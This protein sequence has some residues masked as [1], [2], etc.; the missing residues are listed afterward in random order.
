MLTLQL[1]REKR[2]HKQQTVTYVIM[3]H[4]LISPIVTTT[5]THYR[6]S[7][8]TNLLTHSSPTNLLSMSPPSLRSRLPAHIPL[9]LLRIRSDGQ[10]DSSHPNNPHHVEHEAPRRDSTRVFGQRLRPLVTKKETEEEKCQPEVP[11]RRNTRERGGH[12]SAMRTT[13][14]YDTHIDTIRVKTVRAYPIQ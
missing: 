7:P 8:S 1:N 6:P 13:D 2:E 11:R 14:L 12:T 4:I 5:K 10:D 3:G 9:T